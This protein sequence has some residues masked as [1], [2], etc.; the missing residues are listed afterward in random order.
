DNKFKLDMRSARGANVIVNGNG[1]RIDM[2][3][4]YFN[5]APTNNTFT[6]VLTNANFTQN[7]SDYQ[8]TL[9]SCG[10]IIG[11]TSSNGTFC[12]NN[13]TLKTGD[14]NPYDKYGKKTK[15]WNV[16]A[17]SGAS[18]HFSGTNYLEIAGAV[19]TNTYIGDLRNVEFANDASVTIKGSN[20]NYHPYIFSLTSSFSIGDRA[21]FTI[22]D[23]NAASARRGN[24]F[25]GPVQFRVGNDVTW[26]QH[27]WGSFLTAEDNANT[28]AFFGKRFTLNHDIITEEP[29]STIDGYWYDVAGDLY[30]ARHAPQI[31]FSE[32]ASINIRSKSVSTPIFDLS[33]AAKLGEKPDLA[34]YPNQDLEN[35]PTV[36][37]R[38]DINYIPTL[39]IN[40]PRNLN[41]SYCDE[42]GNPL[43]P[44]VPIIRTA[45]DGTVPGVFILNGVAQPLNLW[46]SSNVSKTPDNTV[47]KFDKLQIWNESTTLY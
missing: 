3:V 47:N 45:R 5:L 22:Y 20:E 42:N 6:F 15:A 43:T 9:V 32:G 26:N 11:D 8:G 17:A 39:V 4:A 46:T 7:T 38:S 19:Y 44:S 27:G 23:G 13:I 33:S 2:G 35:Y 25:W 24:V 36:P 29:I 1:H 21:T 18:V 34:K 16:I 12:F 41:L 37:N 31:V 30:S 28:K 10:R 14:I 40:N